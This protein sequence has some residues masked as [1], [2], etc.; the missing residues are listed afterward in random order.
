MYVCT[1]HTYAKDGMMRIY[2][3]KVLESFGDEVRS[4][5]YGYRFTEMR[6]MQLNRFSA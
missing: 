5:E 4:T 3:A 1:V 2:H 6:S